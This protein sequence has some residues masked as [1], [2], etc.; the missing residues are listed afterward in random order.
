[1]LPAACR[2][3]DS[4][5]LPVHVNCLARPGAAL[6]PC[7]R[8]SR[9]RVARRPA[10]GNRHD[11]WTR[12]RVSRRRSHRRGHRRR[13]RDPA[14]RGVLGSRPSAR[15]LPSTTSTAT[16]LDSSGLRDEPLR[17]PLRRRARRSMSR[18]SAAASRG[19]PPPSR[20]SAA[21]G[22]TRGR[23]SKPHA[24]GYRRERSQRRLR[25][26]RPYAPAVRRLAE[27]HGPEAA[28]RRL[29]R[30]HDRAGRDR[31]LRRGAR[32]RLRLRAQRARIRTRGHSTPSAATRRSR[33]ARA[34]AAM[35]SLP[36]APGRRAR[37]C[38]RL[39]R[40]RSGSTARC[41]APDDRDPESAPS[42]RRGVARV[43][44][45]LGVEI[46]EA[47]RVLRIE[48]AGNDLPSLRSTAASSALRR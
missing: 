17:P 25:G 31:A 29:R 42:W 6:K 24:V 22:S 36:A 34:C 16:G 9:D 20:S 27:S 15:P 12:R 48:P 21:A 35:R 4:S 23:C 8:R 32:R 44:D 40:H 14:P 18:S 38:A 10:R 47:T 43:A 28:A 26:G 11:R 5:G 41:V 1:M 33:A 30:D 37:N 3:L 39:S 2:S 7:P 45:S 13:G 19:L 46:R